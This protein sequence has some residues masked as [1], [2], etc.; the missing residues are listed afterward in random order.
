MRQILNQENKGYLNQDDTT[1]ICSCLLVRKYF[2]THRRPKH[3]VTGLRGGNE[4]VWIL[5]TSEE[6][7][8]FSEYDDF[9][10]KGLLFFN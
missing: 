1:E 5:K 9:C 6:N 3:I 2:K 10:T 4:K 8:R 7:I